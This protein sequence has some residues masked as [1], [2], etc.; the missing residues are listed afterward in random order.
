MHAHADGGFGELAGYQNTALETAFALQ[1]LRSAGNGQSDTAYY[2][3][4]YLLAQQRA[5]GGWETGANA[6][7]VY[8]AAQVLVALTPYANTLMRVPAAL[9]AAQNF[10]LSKRDAANLW[11]EDFLSA[12]ALLALLSGAQDGGAT[13]QA[14]IDVLRSRQMID[15]SWS[16]DVYSTALALRV[17]AMA[18][19]PVANPNL[20]ALQ[21]RVLDGDS[22][23]ALAGVQI[24]LQGAAS[25][26]VAS[27]ADGNFLFNALPPGS[28][29]ATLSYPGYGTLTA[30]TSLSAGKITQLGA[31]NL[32]PAAADP[33]TA[34]IRGTVTDAA[35]GQTLAGVSIVSGAQTAVTGADGNFQLND[36]PPG[37]ITVTAE[38][39]G[40][41]SVSGQAQ[42][43]AGSVLLFS[44]QLTP[45]T[46]L[47]YLFGTITDA[48]TGQPL[49]DVV[50][51]V[52]GATSASI[53]TDAT[54]AYR[55]EPLAAG[56]SVITAS[57]PGYDT[58]YAQLTAF[59]GINYKF[60]PQLYPVGTSTPEAN[61]ASL[62]GIVMDS[63]ANRPLSG[64]TLS[65]TH[66]TTTETLSTD[67]EGR[68]EVTGITEAEV[69]L[70]FSLEN[71]QSVQ[72]LF[73]VT[74]L[75]AE[76]L[77]QIR[78]RPKEVE[79]LL[80]D[81]IAETLTE[82][83]VVTDPQ[84]LAL[85]GTLQAKVKN[86]GTAATATLVEV[87][88]YYDADRDGYYNATVD[89]ALG[90]SYLS[91]PL[92]VGDFENVVITLVGA[93]P[94]RDAPI[95]VW[96][97]SLQVVAE[98]NEANNQAATA[99]A[100][101]GEP[102]PVGTL[103]P[104]VKWG[105]T[106]STYQPSY[107]QVLG[108]PAVAQLNDDNGDGVVDGDDIPD[109]IFNSFYGGNYTGN[110]VL[111]IVSGADGKEL[112]HTTHWV[113][114]HY[115][116]AVGDIDHDGLVEIIIGGP[117]EKGL[118]V[119]E[120]DG[121][122]KWSINTGGPAQPALAD[123]DH[124]GNVEIVYGNRVYNADDGSL[125]WSV[126]GGEIAPLVADLDMDG[127]MDVF[128]GGSAY[129]YD[130]T[131]KWKSGIGNSWSALGNFDDDPYP[132]IV[133]KTGGR[134]NS[135][136]YLLEHTGAVKWG[137]VS[138][139]ALGGGGGGAPTVADFDGDGQ[140]EIGI[141]G[142]SNYFVFETDG[143]LKWKTTIQD[144]TSNI[145]GSSVFDFEGDGK[146]EV[147]Y[148]DEKYFRI[149]DG[150]TGTV[151]YAIKNPSR[152]HWEYPV[153]ADIDNDDHAE[154]IVVANNAY[155]GSGYTGI[156]V[157]EN[158]NDD[159]MPTRSI[160]NQY[161][162]HID[163]VNEDGTIPQ[164]EANSWQSHN[165]YRLN[166]FPNRNVLQ[167]ADLSVSRLMLIDQGVRQLPS[168]SVRVGNGG[169]AEPKSLITVA[170]YQGDPSAGGI[171]LGTVNVDSLTSGQYRD[172]TLD[173]V[174][175]S[176]MDD[177]YAVVDPDNNI[178]EC[179]E[180]NNKISLPLQNAIVSGALQVGVDVPIYGPNSPVLL[181][182]QVR[183]TGALLASF[184]V[185]LR[186]EDAGGNVVVEFPQRWVT[187]LI[188][189]AS[190]NLDEIWNTADY[191]T[192]DY[193]LR[194][195]LYDTGGRFLDEAVAPFQ[196]V[197]GSAARIDGR[198]VTDKAQYAAWDTVAISERVEN[199][200]VNAIQPPTRVELSV[201]APDGRIL[202]EQSAA[203]GEL[204]P[205]DRR[206]LNYSLNLA[207]AAGGDY[208]V[209]MT[210]K[211]ADG[212]AVL[213]TRSTAFRV[214]RQAVQALIGSVAATP[215][216][217]YRGDPVSCL[218][219]VQNRAAA[220][221]PDVLLTH[222]LAAADS[223]QLLDEV[224][225]TVA[226]P[227]L[228]H[229]IETRRIDTA[230]LAIGTY[231][232][233]LLADVEGQS[234]RLG[235][236]LF[237]V[238]EPPVKLDAALQ[239][240]RRG[241]VLV[242]LD[243]GS[244]DDPLGENHRP[245]LAVQ[246]AY[247]ENLLTAAGWSYTLVTDADAFSREL[248]SGGYVVYLLL[249]E[250]VK[251]PETIQ[252]EVREAVNRGDG[253]IEAGGHDQ[254]QGRIDEVL[255][256]KFQGKHAHMDGLAIDPDAFT[257]A[258]QAGLQLSD[259][260]LRFSL[261]GATALGHFLQDGQATQQPALAERVYGLG[262]SVHVG[263]DLLAEAALPDADPRHG[264]LLL[265]ALSRVHPDSLSPLADGV[266][267]LSIKID[268]LRIATPGR[269]VLSLP[270]GVTVID[271]GGA[272]IGDGTLGWNFDLAE[273]ASVTFT[274]W[275]QLPA[276]PL[277][278]NAA[279]DS[280]VAGDYT[281]QSDLTLSLDAPQPDDLQ[282]A[283]DALAP[284][285]DNAYRPVRKYLD[286]AQS[287]RQRQDWPAA[288]DAL[289]RAADALIPIGTAQAADIRLSVDRALHR[290]AMQLPAA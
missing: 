41:Q 278:F 122:L 188:G 40:Y 138:T 165:T 215:R 94:F 28:Y 61:T 204:L 46:N 255:G 199:I 64:V 149:F 238:L 121:R 221:L 163:N 99:D 103:D 136:I 60:S 130:G 181:S 155:W 113:N 150:S 32:L 18:G 223:A 218:E 288:V 287:A 277:S 205:G 140:A 284:L 279:V 198:V 258:G 114:A 256:L 170:V 153:V 191:L 9:T 272:E 259:K 212:N 11:G 222:R 81:L 268:N 29:T 169:L 190:G 85:T 264:Q 200:T 280:G 19:N 262:R 250:A 13:L 260:T 105:W 70:D 66:G 52:S 74:P 285:D 276:G 98:S 267:P 261:D 229:W 25:A 129:N 248:H 48:A 202:L 123:L 164:F 55:I 167:Q 26:Q 73:P 104:V 78:M 23:V 127:M 265:D 156:R 43:Q 281:R 147:L 80:P 180:N 35:T 58:V 134:T 263:Y 187:D 201:A 20:S 87:L 230:D 209:T 83:N 249:S 241:R 59:D 159:W 235:A 109:V 42:V 237:D 107:N 128:T 95:R 145:T 47:N 101:Q 243:A 232:C 196:I 110:G 125:R 172:V 240:G 194:G 160:W 177:I 112:W 220:A 21:G 152:T 31:I 69:T 14:D 24:S 135:K 37:S 161:A 275:V 185:A 251:L 289:R 111:R 97:D 228:G 142:Y 254:R 120:N 175:I 2:A 68:F 143:S 233:L 22:G 282:A 71:Y 157:F 266:L 182:A 30:T 115:G 283:L 179:D 174:H 274:A 76:D 118:K 144:Y 4:D 91:G 67:A 151:L 77:G 84:S 189:D 131:L 203:L 208:P 197:A 210:V 213:L 106:K 207:D 5:D 38:L 86:R 92:P 6:S 108:T 50:I 72:L 57:L 124:D 10:L 102:L 132:E 253:L 82:Q 239:I 148:G 7:S 27:N 62:S 273:A 12:E 39:A 247:L 192:G 146:A 168:V 16:G 225:Q 154:V 45:G 271:A 234:R 216:Q 126:S 44:P 158:R 90:S 88:A 252:Q 195:Y 211:D 227:G 166:T 217:V 141:A 63:A 51:D 183:N 36:V 236:A 206:D 116:P 3:V 162:Y 244:G 226:I 214:E 89:T 34:T 65:V 96:V 1:A 178:D 139:Y 17:L 257:P 33:T 93:L 242:L 246:R 79:V 231:A 286:W 186:I 219:Q 15:G 176:N 224:A 53:T 54:G 193:R 184:R 56:T 137:P 117:A 49:P 171:L 8:V 133:V 119:F 75:T 173:N 245:S 100:C 270:A 269:V 290:A